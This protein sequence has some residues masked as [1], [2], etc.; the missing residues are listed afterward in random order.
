M[1]DT[2]DHGYALL[3]AVNESAANA[4]LPDVI[5][6]VEALRDV[7]VHPQ[8]CGYAA[9]NVKVITAKASTRAG[10]VAGLDWLRL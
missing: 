1:S 6:D 5:K 8:R 7:L 2:F 10:I 4:A 9:D 3:I